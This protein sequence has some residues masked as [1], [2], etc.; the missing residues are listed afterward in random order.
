ME[1]A[2]QN[3]CSGAWC[4]VVDK[5]VLEMLQMWQ[6][7]AEKWVPALLIVSRQ[8]N[9]VSYLADSVP[10]PYGCRGPSRSSIAPV[11]TMWCMLNL[12]LV[13]A[14]GVGLVQ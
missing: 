6:V 9:K 1:S 3:A 14:A 13:A 8:P 7:H 5:R 10:R 11:V 12:D 2:R 4:H